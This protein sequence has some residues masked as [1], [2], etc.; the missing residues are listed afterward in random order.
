[1]YNHIDIFT[2]YKETVVLQQMIIFI[3]NLPDSSFPVVLPNDVWGGQGG[4]QS[5]W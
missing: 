2:L 1:M 5:H 4:Q 3:V